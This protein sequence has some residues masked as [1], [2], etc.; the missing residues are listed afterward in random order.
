[1]RDA[2]LGAEPATRVEVEEPLRPRRPLL[3][4]GRERGQHL[5]PGGGE[6]AAEPELGRRPRH[7][8]GEERL[9]LVR[10]QAGEPGAVAAG[11]PV[12]ACGPAYRLDRDSGRR[13]R[14]D[15]AMDRAHRHLQPL[16]YVGGR[17]LSACLEQ[18]QERDESGGAH[19][20][21]TLGDKHDRRWPLCLSVS[22]A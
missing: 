19:P 2:V 15:V 7:A 4:F 9:R 6:L 11:E 5:Q 22:R 20:N 21:G 1:M 10:G 14:L 8:R 18:Q 13:E 17:E 16:G 12:A 3:E